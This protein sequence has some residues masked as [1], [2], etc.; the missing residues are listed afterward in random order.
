MQKDLPLR[1]KIKG[2]VNISEFKVKNRNQ[3]IYLIGEDHTQ[4]GNSP[5]I[6]KDIAQ[7]IDCPIHVLVEK[8]FDTFWNMEL[9]E[10]VSN[11][12]LFWIPPLEMCTTK[13]VVPKD[14]D[15][16]KHKQFL[17]KCI[18][19]YKGRV[20]IWA[21]DIRRTSIF[22]LVFRLGLNMVYTLGEKHVLWKIKNNPIW[23]KWY[24]SVVQF[25]KHLF[26][27]HLSKQMYNKKIIREIYKIYYLL[28]QNTTP[29]LKK[30][31]IRDLIDNILKTT[32]KSHLDLYEEIQMFSPELRSK[33][34]YQ[35]K[36]FLKKEDPI[37]KLLL[38]G[39]FDL[40]CFISLHRILKKTKN[41]LVLMFMGFFHADHLTE[42]LKNFPQTEFVSRSLCSPSTH[43]F[44]LL[45]PSMNCPQKTLR[46]KL[47]LQRIK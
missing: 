23:K 34:E 43:S 32:D 30:H 10:P 41:G 12:S 38:A 46:M 28:P 16:L 27:F 37:G 11:S 26:N 39:L 17:N 24:Q 7:N 21:V 29:R 5:Q 6:L 33:L 2:Y 35:F 15:L 18:L 22:H 31:E 47:F 14:K 9:I 45:V 42:L 25:Q 44:S 40:N 8:S 13:G 3:M 19:P 20:K 4:K 36:R 1:L